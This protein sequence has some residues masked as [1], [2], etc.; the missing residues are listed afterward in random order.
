DKDCRV[1]ETIYAAG[2]V[3]HRPALVNMAVLES[4]HAV[5]HMFRLP[6]RPL[7]FPNMS[8]VMFFYPAV[9]AVGLNEKACRRKAIA[10][11]AAVY[12]NALLPRAI[13]MRASLGFVKIIVSDDEQQRILGMRAAG[14]QVSS[15]IMSV[16]L[17]IDRNMSAIDVLGTMFP[18]PTMSEGIQECLRLL[19][20]NS[21]YRAEAFPDLL[22][23]RSWR[24]ERS[25]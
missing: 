1:H 17:L 10:Y 24:P 13:A 12:A 18:H 23:I 11:R 6:A 15:T 22:S 25:A 20:G 16:A 5:K 8:T 9:A 14:P 21:V 3:T 19:T 7:N 2:D 4:R